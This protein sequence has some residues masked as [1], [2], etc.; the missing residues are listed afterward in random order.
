MSRIDGSKRAVAAK[1]APSVRPCAARASALA[2]DA[3][4]AVDWAGA[5][6]R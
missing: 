6:A 5:G 2:G 3:A 1:S 4:A